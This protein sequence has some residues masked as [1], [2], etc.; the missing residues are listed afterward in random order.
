[1]LAPEAWPNYVLGNHDEPRLSKRL[2]AG[3]VRLAGLLLLTLRG[4]PTLYYGD[5]LGMAEGKVPVELQKDPW[6]FR[7]G[8]PELSRD[9]CRTPM[10]WDASPTAG[11]S[12][13]SPDDLW[14]PLSPGHETTNVE[15]ERADP[16]SHLAFYR[17]AL[18]LRSGS[19][20]LQAGSYTP[21]EDLPG[22]VFAFTREDGGDRKLVLLHFGDGP[23]E[24]DVPEA[25]RQGHIAL[26]THER[27]SEG[28]AVGGRVTLGPWAGLVIGAA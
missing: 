9:G 27:A 8:L 21:M 5:E 1:M 3:S 25:F 13:A 18:R 2:G 15:A 7:S 14:L 19:P 4:T 28:Q 20:A 10:A 16:D 17:R 24:V 11:F 23:V 6:G 12:D 22:D 26:A